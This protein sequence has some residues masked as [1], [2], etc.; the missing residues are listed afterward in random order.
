MTTMSPGRGSG[1][2]TLLD[3]G[4]ESVA[5]DR[6]V[7]HEGRDHAAHGGAGDE[8][9]GFP[10][11]MRDADARRS[12]R[13]QR[14]C[15]RAMLVEA[16]VSSMKTK[17]FRHVRR[18]PPPADSLNHHRANS[19]NPPA[20]HFSSASALDRQHFRANSMAAAQ[21]QIAEIRV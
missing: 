17:R 16:Q 13:R 6:P 21:P 11:A 15:V 7:E 18:P 9:R 1:T 3:I 4:L 10:M 14:P 8:G 2:R 12:P 20:I 19:E 5:V